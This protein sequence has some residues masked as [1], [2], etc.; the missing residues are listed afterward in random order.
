M[1]H[2]RS[3]SGLILLPRNSSMSL[4]AGRLR[5]KHREDLIDACLAAWT[6]ALWIERGAD[7]CQVLGEHDCF[8]DDRVSAQLSSHRR[9][10]RSAHTRS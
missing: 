6:A 9:D 4:A 10:P 5:Y 2:R 7:R 1:L 8:V 3:I